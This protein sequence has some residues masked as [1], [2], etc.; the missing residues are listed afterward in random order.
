MMGGGGG[1]N[2][3]EEDGRNVEKGEEKE[4]KEM[5][6]DSDTKREKGN[7]RCK[8]SDERRRRRRNNEVEKILLNL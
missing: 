3:E 4:V 2:L 1:E 8:E 5:E 6:G 7:D